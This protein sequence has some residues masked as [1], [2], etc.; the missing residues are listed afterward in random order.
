[1]IGREFGA[2]PPY[3][4][5]GYTWAVKGK[6]FRR[7]QS[8]PN[9]LTA[10]HCSGDDV[11]SRERPQNNLCPPRCWNQTVQVKRAFSVTRDDKIS[12]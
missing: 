1:L 2:P 3:Q 10:C 12:A 11:E 4:V 8:W 7:Q 9:F 5:I 6:G